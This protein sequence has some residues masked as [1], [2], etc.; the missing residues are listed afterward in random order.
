M[1]IQ[2]MFLGFPPPS[3]G[4]G[5]DFSGTNG[6]VYLNG[7]SV[8]E[9]DIAGSQFSIPSN[10]SFC[11]EAWVKFTLGNTYNNVCSTWDAT[12]GYENTLFHVKDNGTIFMAGYAG[13]TYT[14]N[15]GVTANN[16]HHVCIASN[17][18]SGEFYIDGSMKGGYTNSGAMDSGRPLYVGA[19]MDGA[20]GSGN[21]NYRPTG[22]I[23]NLRFVVGHK[24][25]DSNFT[26]PDGALTATSQG[27]PEGACKLLAFQDANDW[28]TTYQSSASFSMITQ[29]GSPTSSTDHPFPSNNGAVSFNT[30]SSLQ[31]AST[32]DLCPGTGDFTFE[33]WIKPNDWSGTWMTVYHNGAYDGFYVGKD[34]SGNFVVRASS[35]TSFIE[36][37]SLPTV[38]QWT[39]IAVTREG[40]TLKLFYN[41]VEKN[42]VSNSHNFITAATGIGQTTG[43][44]EGINGTLSN[45]RFVKGTAVYTSAFTTPTTALTVIANTEL[46]CC[47]KTTTT[48]SSITPTTINTYGSPGATTGPF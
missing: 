13:S 43:P 41:G 16:W 44:G 36:Q 25:Y 28:Q 29:A 45:L 46:L 21:G 40:S 17:G 34:S 12:G 32:S 14:S 2:Q 10:T 38:N 5:G 48:G 7:S 23:S 24:T 18:S 39:H 35:N 27:V 15:S 47:N 30:S 1:A 6:S 19:N 37:S 8:I 31:L 26:P 4:G 22:Y 42:S 20:N 9:A 11:I 3:S 33:C